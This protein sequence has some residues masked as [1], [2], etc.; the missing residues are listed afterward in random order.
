M[1]L[2]IT[3]SD[4]SPEWGRCLAVCIGTLAAGLLLLFALML[5]VDPYDSGRFG[6]LGIDGVDDSG[7]DA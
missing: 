4:S 7:I 5:L 1:A 3:A 6:L 2:P